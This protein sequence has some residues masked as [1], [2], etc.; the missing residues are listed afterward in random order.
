MWTSR[1]DPC[2][3]QLSTSYSLARRDLRDRIDNRKVVLKI[4]DTRQYQRTKF[5]NGMRLND[6]P[7]PGNEISS[8]GNHPLYELMLVRKTIYMDHRYLTLEVFRL[9]DLAGEEATSEGP[10]STGENEALPALSCARDSRVCDHG[11]TEF[12]A[13][14]DHCKVTSTDIP[15]HG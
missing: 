7:P 14:R 11:Y 4:L 12:S 3:A 6:M 13:S 15:S 8:G 1:G 10:V 2:N 9:F 5:R